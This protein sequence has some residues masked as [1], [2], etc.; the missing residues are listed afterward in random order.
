MTTQEE[1]SELIRQGEG[2]TVEFKRSEIL[3]HNEELAKLMVALAN[4]MG[5]KIL[6]GVDDDGKF[7]GMKEK[8]GHEEHIVNIARDKIDPPLLI[9]FEKI[10]IGDFNVYVVTVPRFSEF[11]HAL[12]TRS[13]NVYFIRVGTTIRQ[14]SPS[15]LK[16][17]FTGV[18]APMPKK[19]MT[20]SDKTGDIVWRVTYPRDLPSPFYADNILRM[21]HFLVEFEIQNNTGEPINFTTYIHSKNQAIVFVLTN[22]KRIWVWSPLPHHETR[23][24]SLDDFVQVQ[25]PENHQS[26]KFTF[27][28]VY[29]PRYAH[30]FYPGRIVLTYE[31]SGR[32]LSG[33]R[34]ESGPHRIEI[35][36]AEEGKGKPRAAEGQTSSR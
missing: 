11:P 24:I 22:P 7:E 19:Q 2:P 17:M 21:Y 4:T 9:Q 31:L 15:E 26:S 29:R 14:P 25:V 28:A 12:K 30:L 13:G 16:Q 6:I 3:S 27:H 35:P 20:G 32:T 33:K 34:F 36:F 5:G 18:F 8:I 23:N 10:K 1:L